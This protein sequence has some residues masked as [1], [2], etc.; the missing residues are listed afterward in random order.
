[1]NKSQLQTRRYEK[2]HLI[3]KRQKLISQL[4]EVL[5]MTMRGSG[6]NITFLRNL[7]LKKNACSPSPVRQNGGSHSSV[8]PASENHPRSP[9]QIHVNKRIIEDL[10]QRSEWTRKEIRRIRMSVGVEG[11]KDL[12]C[13]ST[14]CFVSST[15]SDCSGR[16]SD[17]LIERMYL[18]FE[19]QEHVLKTLHSVLFS[20]W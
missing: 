1:M 20:R 18:C 3:T 16:I 8:Y 15:E 12:L 7:F 4:T 10:E 2:L 13:Y 19:G 14:S 17:D 5:K 11:W 6:H 9:M